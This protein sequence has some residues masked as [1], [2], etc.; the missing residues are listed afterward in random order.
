MLRTTDSLPAAASLNRAARAAIAAEDFNL[1]AT[2]WQCARLA[3][4]FG[5]T[6]ASQDVGHYLQAAAWPHVARALQLAATSRPDDALAEVDRARE[7]LPL[8]CDIAILMV[9]T[10]AKMGQAKLAD[11][12][13]EKYASFID[14]LLEKYPRS[15]DLHNKAAWLRARCRRQLDEALKHA[16]QA[17]KLDPQQA[18]NLDSLAEAHFQ[19][20]DRAKAIET[21]ERAIK[22]EPQRDYFR[23]QADRFRDGDP[24]S[25][26]LELSGQ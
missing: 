25:P 19:R 20:G 5:D 13:F 11:A 16:E 2:Y 17:V 22:L 6:T 10:L 9:N 4:F 3:H 1:A 15:P 21:I 18:N 26:P 12:V 8:D 14:K 24:K 23:S 7:L